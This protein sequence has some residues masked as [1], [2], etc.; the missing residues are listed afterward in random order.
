MKQLPYLILQSILLLL[1]TVTGSC[2]SSSS[3]PGVYAGVRLSLNPLG[4]GMNRSDEVILFR[5]NKTFN[6]Q[7]NKKDW[8]TAVRGKYEI[9]GSKVILSYTNGDKGDL[10]ITKGGNLDAGTYVMFKM[11]LNNKVPKGAYEFKFISGAGGISTGTTYVGTSSR[12]ELIFD[13]AGNFTTDRQ[14]TTV[15]AGDN[16]GGGTNT[17]SDGGGKYTL[18]DG[19][20]ELN[21]DNGTRTTHSF[22]ASAGDGKAKAMA[23]IDGSFYFMNDESEE[24]NRLSSNTKLPTAKEIFTQLR[25]SYGGKALDDVKRYTVNAEFNGIKLI[26]YNDLEGKRFRNEMYQNGKLIVV[27]QIGEDGGWQWTQGKKA[28]VNKDRL[29]VVKYNDHIGVLGLRDEFA[30]AFSKGVVKATSN[31]YSVNFQVDG[32]RFEY[33]LD[34]N[35][36]ILSDNYQIGASK[37]ANTYS[38]NKTIDGIKMPFKTIATDGKTKVTITYRDMD[39]NGPLKTDWKELR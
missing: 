33:V 6:D 23:V 21:Y 2:Q 29:M 27:E 39:I 4:G 15:I 1:I 19:V 18:K 12:R 7:L 38:N 13:G 24:S 25:K 31:G 10:D 37:Q 14:S 34:R 3:F 16:I 35:Y 36:I 9:K 5:S 28:S 26:S 20:L 11:E 30:S 17:K 32:N 22:F 8:K